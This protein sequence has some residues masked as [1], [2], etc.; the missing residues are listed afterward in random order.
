MAASEYSH[1]ASPPLQS[2]PAQPDTAESFADSPRPVSPVFTHIRPL[3]PPPLAPLDPSDPAALIATIGR[4][5]ER[6]AELVDECGKRD[7]ELY[8]KGAQVRQLRAL[9][10]EALKAQHQH[11]LKA[12][13]LLAQMTS[14]HQEVS[15]AQILIFDLV[16]NLQTQ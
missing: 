4:Q 8:R 5:R 14:I 1:V 3:S 2:Q 12:E 10:Q 16:N 13:E 7:R 6:I 11:T 15:S 9:H